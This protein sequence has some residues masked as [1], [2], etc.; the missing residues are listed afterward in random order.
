MTTS[1]DRFNGL[2]GSAA[3]K[4]PCLAATVS[5]VTLSG[6]QSIDG[7]SLVAGDRVLVKNQTTGSENGIY[8]VSTGDWVRASDLNGSFDAVG[9][10]QV[11]IFD[12]AVN[13]NKVFVLKT[14]NFTIGTTALTFEEFSSGGGGGSSNLPY[15]NVKDYGALGDGSTDDT[16]AIQ[17]CINIG[18]GKVWFPNG[19]YVVT[20]IDVDI[21]SVTLYGNGGESSKLTLKANSNRSVILANK[22]SGQLFNFTCKGMFI[23][24]NRDNQ[25]GSSEVHGIE[26]KSTLNARIVDCEIYR[27]RESGI[28]IYG[29][30][31]NALAVDTYIYRNKIFDVGRIGVE[32]DVFAGTL[33]CGHNIIGPVTTGAGPLFGI[34]INNV[35]TRVHDNHIFAALENNIR[36]ER[37]FNAQINDNHIESSREHGVHIN[38]SKKVVMTGNTIV[39]SGRSGTPSNAG[40]YSGIFISKVNG[41]GSAAEDI[42]I[43]GNSSHSEETTEDVSGTPTLLQKYGCEIEFADSLQ[44]AIIKD[45]DFNGNETG[46]INRTSSGTVKIE[47]NLP[48]GERHAP[49]VTYFDPDQNAD[50]T[51][52]LRISIA[53]SNNTIK[54]TAG[55]WDIV[56]GHNN[57]T[58]GSGITGT[59]I[60]TVNKTAEG[61]PS[62]TDWWPHFFDR[63]AGSE[64]SGIV[65]VNKS[66]NNSSNLVLDIDVTGR[67]GINILCQQRPIANSP[68]NFFTFTQS[69]TEI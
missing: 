55:V 31:S 33:G 24:G 29:T 41:S 57:S 37:S 12:G 2:V 32:F 50:E 23:E 40:Q 6:E 43:V 30:A 3:I 14:K 25:T 4:L 44:N 7:V 49:D 39:K 65:T 48:L 60:L 61:V 35:D 45:N 52:R 18:A 59:Y 66:T 36:V 64:D 34:R 38:G 53:V 19:N 13:E 54:G 56:I 8:V 46:G 17:A 42:I 22:S 68:G 9:G 62:T 16:A 58:N 69:I 26:L 47:D 21:D 15:R 28:K 27:T 10:T 11:Y 67:K 5:N 63:I 20:G 1:T 51:Q